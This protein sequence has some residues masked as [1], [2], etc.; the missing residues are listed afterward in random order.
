MV[1]KFVQDIRKIVDL[2]PVNNTQTDDK[3]PIGPSIGVGTDVPPVPIVLARE[4]IYTLV[5]IID[6][7]GGPRLTVDITD[8][9]DAVAEIT[10]MVDN[11]F[12]DLSIILKP[13]GVFD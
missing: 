6:G 11:D 2:R 4:G 1:N 3:A 5:E 13:N 12:T 10:T 7:T 9:T 8:P